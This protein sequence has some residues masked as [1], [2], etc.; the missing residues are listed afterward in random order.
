MNT[1]QKI[2]I[3]GF[4]SIGSGLLP[5]LLKHFDPGNITIISA[6][7][8][9]I[10][11]SAKYG[12]AHVILEITQQNYQHQLARYLSAG[13]MLVNLSVD[14]SSQALVKLCAQLHVLYL[15][16]CIE[17]WAGYYTDTSQS[18]EKRTNYSLRQDILDLRQL[19]LD[20]GLPPGPTAIM[21]HGANPGL[22]NHF[23]KQA[24]TH[25]AEK[26]RPE[27][28]KTPPQSQRDWATLAQRVGL[29][30]VHI[31]ERDT[32]TPHIPKAVGEFVNTWSVDGFISEALQPSELAWGTH[33]RH[34]PQDAN[35]FSWGCKSSIWL[36]R[37]G[38]STQVR[39]WTPKQGTFHGWLITHNE[40]VSI[41]DY[42][43][44]NDYQPTVMYAYHPCDSAVLSLLELC[45]SGFVEQPNKRLIVDQVT[46]GTDELGVL[47]MG[48]FG[49]YW[50]GSQLD[51]DTA[52]S[53]VPHNNA[54]SL[55]V[56]APVLAGILYAVANPQL[57]IVEADQL[58][59]DE[60]IKI[61]EPY[62]GRLVGV[63]TDWCPLQGR[64]RL[65]VEDVD[66][67]DPWQ[68]KNFRVV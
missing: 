3:L 5:L 6:D 33:E 45:G 9:N 1:Q 38:C 50:Y 58:P 28:L 20:Q 44:K 59:H 41:G 52:R 37:P 11:T 51:I 30:V 42:F 24:L 46:S 57:G 53:L 64:G 35:R 15:D 65:F 10:N 4:G 49:A 19:W 67:Q 36:S 54:T 23:V 2:V 13:S 60:I 17:P 12:V 47:L 61:T 62:L 21:A 56:V 25:V 55:Q 39:T 34:W 40:S 31:A 68:F 16:T 22:V 32:Q 27:L 29:K 18:P 7:K 48:D 66:D 8:R 63:W 26:H 43:N 14:V